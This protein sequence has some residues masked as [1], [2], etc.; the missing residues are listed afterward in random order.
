MSDINKKHLN[1]TIFNT[2]KHYKFAI[3]IINFLKTKQP[4]NVLCRTAEKKQNNKKIPLK[5]STSKKC[6]TNMSWFGIYTMY[7][8]MMSNIIIFLHDHVFVNKNLKTSTTYNMIKKNC[9]K[10]KKQN[11]MLIEKK[12]RQTAEYR[13]HQ[14]YLNHYYLNH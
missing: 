4:K 12:K 13:L 3:K 10:I 8:I 9:T 14:Q 11:T 7:I 5:K 6:N 1:K 2:I